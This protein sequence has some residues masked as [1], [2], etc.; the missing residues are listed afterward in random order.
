MKCGQLILRKMVKTVATRCRILTLK[1]T[2]LDFGCVSAPVPTV[3]GLT[4]FPEI[5]WLDL[6]GRH[7]MGGMVG[8]GCVMA[9]GGWTP[10]GSIEPMNIIISSSSTAL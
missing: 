9:V 3:G 5:P 6:R 8:K 7:L 1:C 2:K 4:A 10:P